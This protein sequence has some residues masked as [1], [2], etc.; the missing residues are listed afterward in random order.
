MFLYTI[1]FLI[2]IILYYLGVFRKGKDRTKME[3]MMLA[4]GASM[5]V[6]F[7]IGVYFGGLF[8]GTFFSSLLIS[9]IVTSVIGIIIGVPHGKLCT[10]EGLFTGGMAGLMGAMTAEMLSIPEVRIILLLLLLLMGLGAFWSLYFWKNTGENVKK[11]TA[12]LLHF[13]TMCYLLCVTYIFI[14]VPPFD[15][16]SDFPGHGHA[17]STILINIY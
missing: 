12:Y 10:I 14:W 3:K 9:V 11:W 13:T 6:G 15:D 2:P 4:M 5:L 16:K 8:H 17:L 7:S 1:L